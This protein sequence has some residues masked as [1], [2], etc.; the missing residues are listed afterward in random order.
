MSFKSIKENVIRAKEETALK[1]SRLNW[2]QKAVSILSS[3]VIIL[4]FTVIVYVAKVPVI[5]ESSDLGN[6][7]TFII[8][9][10][11]EHIFSIGIGWNLYTYDFKPRN[12]EQFEAFHDLLEW[13]GADIVRQSVQASDWLPTPDRYDDFNTGMMN[14]HFA[15][16]DQMEKRK[17][18]FILANWKLG[19]QWLAEL[20]EGTNEI[21]WD[22]D[23]FNSAPKDPEKFADVYAKLLYH[24]VNEKK[25]EYFQYFSIWN[26]PEGPWSYN[27]IERPYP[28]GFLEM[29]PVFD[30]KLKEYGIRDSIK[31]FG[32]DV[33]PRHISA[34]KIKT[35]ADN[36]I[37]VISSHDYYYFSDFNPARMKGDKLSKG[38]LFYENMINEF[39]TSYGKDVPI[40]LG[41][42]GNFGGGP[43]TVPDEP[44]IIYIGAV[45][46]AETV[47]RLINVGVDGFLQWQFGMP[48]DGH[49][50]TN[51]LRMTDEHLFV[52]LAP[53]YYPHAILSRYVK[54]GSE[55]LEIQRISGPDESVVPN[56][57]ATALRL[58]DG[59]ITVLMVNN[60]IIQK[61][62]TLDLSAL[63]IED[64][65]TVNHL[66][67][68][69]PSAENGINISE[70]RHLKDGILKTT[71]KPRS[72]NAF[73]TS[74][75]GDLE[76]PERVAF[77][78]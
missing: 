21:P 16:W 35:H 10:E 14:V 44:N 3:M 19:V 24:L 52:P 37:D 20:N 67:V 77:K 39:K 15:H 59:N 8:N 36:L 13:T 78:R 22:N 74:E 47:I 7:T 70:I 17:I 53:V 5:H 27:S 45:S 76:L 29:Y 40:V 65:N 1:I 54:A 72:I 9:D 66:Y 61:E 50:N 49:Y 51:A 69:G 30:K 25:Y 55:V 62:I 73:T 11:T 34:E 58:P 32:P 18:P 56:V 28:D 4:A 41:E 43:G 75:P 46:L 64:I 26:E 2:I 23:W 33:N 60:A 38:I 12:L 48:Q 63:N 68:S 42:Y 6:T 71:V 57:Y 31:L